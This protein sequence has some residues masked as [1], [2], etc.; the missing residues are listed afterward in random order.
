MMRAPI[1]PFSTFSSRLPLARRLGV[2]IL[3]ALAATITAVPGSAQSAPGGFSLPTPSPTPAPAPQ[4]PEDERSGVRIAPQ[5][6]PENQPTAS[7]TPAPAAS[8]PTPIP[9]P[10]RPT[11]QVEGRAAPLP[12]A[13]TPTPSSSLPAT[14]RPS[15]PVSLPDISGP[16]SGPDL[17]PD[18]GP[19]FS[20]DLTPGEDEGTIGPDGWYDVTPSGQTGSAAVPTAPRNTDNGAQSD[21]RD[22]ATN[23]AVSIRNRVFVGLAL[24]IVLAAA[25]GGLFWR[26][27]KLEQDQPDSD[28]RSIAF[29]LQ[30]VIAQTV[31]SEAEQQSAN[32][33][34]PATPTPEQASKPELKPAPESEPWLQPAAQ[35][36]PAPA[37]QK[38]SATP[39]VA[40][41]PREPAREPA[42]LD[43]GLEIVGGSRSLMM[44]SIDFRLDIANR[45]D[46]AVRDLNVLGQLVC[47]QRGGSQ[48]APIAGRQLITELDRV[49][50]QQ[51][52]RISGQ[53]QLPLNEVKTIRQ[54]SKPLFIPLLHL[55]IEVPRQPEMNRSFVIG[56]PSASSQNR[57]HPLPLDGPPGGLPGLRA[58]LI[59]QMQDGNAAA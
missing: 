31:P 11:E 8:A 25:L 15:E 54:G 32:P 42:R 19:G 17:G 10:T 41:P 6:I 55:T 53:L 45:S 46:S 37:A 9:T 33:K 57:V 47:A 58:Q 51:S 24:M 39:A 14:R 7:P 4:G 52:C 38:R 29:G 43:L 12:R 18:V 5:V 21:V 13:S 40:T 44:F 23:G 59:K 26:R 28:G 20:S 16:V 3:L 1:Y 56:N 36:A 48:A 30:K 35:P 27:R 2:P 34:P 22:I 50:P 49:G